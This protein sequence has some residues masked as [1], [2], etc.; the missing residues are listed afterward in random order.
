MVNE[1]TLYVFLTLP[2]QTH[3]CLEAVL[4]A[5]AGFHIEVS[6]SRANKT[7]IAMESMPKQAS[8]QAE[9]IL[10]KGNRKIA[11]ES[12]LLDLAEVAAARQRSALH[13]ESGIALLVGRSP[14]CAKV[15][16]ACSY[17]NAQCSRN[18]HRIQRDKVLL[19]LSLDAFLISQS[20]CLLI[21]SIAL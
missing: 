13:S 1:S 15:C 4:P 21:A 14:T 5:R 9:R 11:Y 6:R 16:N 19:R 12:N 10:Q 17:N 2:L 18:L 20:P 3:S 7:S 8:S